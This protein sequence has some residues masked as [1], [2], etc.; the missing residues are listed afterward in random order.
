MDHT[1]GTDNGKFNCDQF[2]RGPSESILRLHYINGC[3]FTTVVIGTALV[4][5]CQHTAQPSLVH[6]C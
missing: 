1:F 4:V 5:Y 3:A 2:S 6:H